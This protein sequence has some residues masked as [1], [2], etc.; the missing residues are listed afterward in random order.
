MNIT[1]KRQTP[2]ASVLACVGLLFIAGQA[3]AAE[4]WLCAKAG[5]VTLPDGTTAGRSVPIWGYVLDTTNFGNN[6]AGTPTLPGPPLSVPSADTTGLTV[7]LRNDLP[8]RNLL[9]AEPTSIV[10]PGQTATMIPVKVTDPQGRQ[11]VRSFTHE[12]APGGTANYVWSSIKPGTYLYHSGT[13]PQ[14]QV[15]MGLYGAL[16]RNFLDGVPAVPEVPAVPAIPPDPNIPG[17]PGT[18]GTPAIPAV[19]AVPGQAYEGVPYTA[20]LTLL[21]SEIDPAQHDAIAAGTYGTTGAP[22]TPC[23]DNNNQSAPRFLPMTSTLCYKPKYYLVNGKPFQASDPAVAAGSVGQDTLL[24]LLNAGLKSYVP[25][26]QGT[27]MKMIAEDGNRYQYRDG[28]VGYP[29]DQYQYSTL[30]ASLKTTDAI[31]TPAT[32]DGTV[33]YDRRL[34]LVNNLAQDGGMFVR[35]SAACSAGTCTDLTISKT[36]GVT[37]VHTGDAV[38]YTIT[39]SNAGPTA[40]TGAQVTDTLPASLTGATWTCAP[41]GAAVCA[42]ASGSGSIATTVDLPVGDSVTFT[43]SG[44]VA[45]GTTGSVVN[46]ASVAAPSGVIDANPVNNSATDTDSILDVTGSMVI[47]G[48]AAA[49]NNRL[50]T[51]T[52]NANN[53]A[54]MRFSWNGTTWFAWEAYATTRTIAL[55][56]PDG[57]KTVYVQFRGAAPALEVSAVYSDTIVLDRIAPTGGSVLINGGDASTALRDVTLSLGATDAATSVTSMRLRWGGQAWGAW[58]PYATTQGATIPVGTNGTKTVAVQFRDAAGNVSTTATDTIQLAD[59]TP[60]TGSV[61]INNGA[62]STN[63]LAVTLN[64]SAADAN[65]VPSMRLRWNGQGWGAW[66]PYAAAQNTTIPSATPGTKTVFVQFRDGAGVLSTVYTDTITYAP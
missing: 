63:A 14:V 47:N 16:T 51:L 6:C 38:S 25:T 45:A 7:H 12:A 56:L 11:R 2:L 61:S 19:P 32:L 60:P 57:V 55:P 39:V 28:A 13:H 44:T 49:T 34:N 3:A 42:A 64:L 21:F 22:A 10:I 8:P 53:A 5:S 65:G 20:E 36:D 24:R 50:V 9:P 46:T 4:Y 62:A 30:L 41:T 37:G 18:P 27:H 59:L 48:D 40:V 31:V 26:I 52:L 1:T 66:M 54:Q 33:I 23:L 29:R 35:L 43:V 58:M 17:D 15:Q